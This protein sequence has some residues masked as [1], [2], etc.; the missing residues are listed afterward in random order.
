[1]SKDF[2]T[3][4]SQK[5][6]IA[7]NNSIIK[8]QQMHIV[9]MKIG[10][11]IGY[12]QDGKGDE[13]LRPVLVYKKFNNRVFLGIPLTSKPKNDKF[14]FEFE[15]KNGKESFA[16]LSQLKLFD[17][18]RAKYYDGRISKR[19]FE[20]LQ[21]KLLN[22]IVTPLTK[23]GEC[24]KAI[25]DDSISDKNKIVNSISYNILVTGSNGQLGNELR[26]LSKNYTN[27]F[28][29]TDR[30]S[31]DI[32]DKEAIF[33]FVNNNNIDVIINCGA[34][35][36]VDKAQTQ[37]SLADEVNR[38][39]VKKLAKVALKNNVKLIH[40]STDYVFNGRAYKPYQ[41]I[42]QTNP[43]TVYGKTKLEGE[44]E[45]IKINP[46][47]SIIIRTSWVYSN[48]GSNFLK[49]MLNL[50]KSQEELGVIY[51]QVGTPTYAKDLAQTVLEIIPKLD[52]K[53]VEIYHYSNEGV[54]SW[55]DFAK[56]IMRMAKLE[57]S[58]KP[59]ES[60]DYPTPAQRPH[61][62]VLNKTKI[63]D[64]FGITI[65]YWKDSLKECLDTIN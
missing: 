20:L 49:T 56:E 18:K 42:E 10:V 28:Y 40:I 59:I 51:D 46:L 4:N 2:D 64:K 26:E 55:Y 61:Y 16:I 12:E 52:N 19:H 17:I 23:E 60:K 62:S 22:L 29:F 54:V 14:H 5:K 21:E 3:W 31:L 13:F 7:D 27:N 53:K 44:L 25:C 15:Y 65:P 36:A 63:K 35:T 47:N 30:D 1:M 6:S 50:G 58:I 57:C 43:K 33:T 39:A 8:F 34:Y 48:F 11:N 37:E 38:K 41:E 24:T 9:F 32:T 45:M